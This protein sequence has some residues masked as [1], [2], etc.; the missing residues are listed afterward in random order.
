MHLFHLRRKG[1]MG[2]SGYVEALQPYS[3]SRRLLSYRPFPEERKNVNGELP[4]RTTS[5]S[6]SVQRQAVRRLCE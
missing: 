4:Y 6:R 1:R 3:Q 5:R 2:D